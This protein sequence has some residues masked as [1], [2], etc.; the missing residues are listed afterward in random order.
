MIV[1]IMGTVVALLMTAGGIWL[2][3]L[4]MYPVFYP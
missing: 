2:M 3:R 4:V 1:G